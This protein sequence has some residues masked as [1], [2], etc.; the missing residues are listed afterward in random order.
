MILSDVSAAG[1]FGK[2]VLIFRCIIAFEM[3]LIMS[4]MPCASL[5]PSWKLYNHPPKTLYQDVATLLPAPAV[6]IASLLL[7]Y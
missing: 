7:H 3:Y 6:T 4:L 1:I 5:N 2:W